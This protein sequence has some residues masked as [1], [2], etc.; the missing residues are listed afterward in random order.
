VTFIDLNPGPQE[1]EEEGMSLQEVEEAGITAG[2][3]TARYKAKVTDKSKA[4]NRD[5]RQ[6]SHPL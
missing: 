6:S 1:V 4:E 5:F 2:C 3:G